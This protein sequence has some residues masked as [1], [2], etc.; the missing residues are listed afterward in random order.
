MPASEVG[1]LARQLSQLLLM[2]ATFF[3]AATCSTYSSPSRDCQPVVL[4]VTD[5]HVKR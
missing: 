5:S 1:W 4:I 3:H 2:H